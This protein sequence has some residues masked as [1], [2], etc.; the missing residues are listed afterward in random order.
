MPLV[1]PRDKE[2]R[3][4]FLERCMGDQTSVNDFPDRS[5]RFAVCNGLYNDKKEEDIKMLLEEEKYHKKPKKDKARVG[6]DEYDN[7]GEAGARAKEI[8]CSGV[9]SHDTP[10]GKVFMP[11]KTHDEYMNQLAKMKKPMEDDEEENKPKRHYGEEHDKDKK[12]KKKELEED[13]DCMDGT[14]GC[15]CTEKQIFFAEIKTEQEGVF[16]GYASTFGNVDN[17]NDIVAKGAFTKSLA[18]RPASKVKLL[19]QHKTDEPIGIFE[20]IFEDSKGLY[21]KGRL[22]LGTQK[23]RETYELMKMGAI[24]GMSIGFRANPEKQTYNES[25]RTRTLNE[26]Q[27]LEI[28][29][30]TF[31]MNERAIVQSVKGEKSIREWE[32]I[33]RD[34]GGLSRTEAKVGA[35]A[36]MDALNHRD[37]DTKQLADLIYKVANILSNKQTNI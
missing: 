36:L 33:L 8:G 23:G 30:V 2:K 27:L 19:S 11:C 12:P 4:D 15:G 14:C 18:E 1:K 16:M 32:T 21:V 26:V 9:H 28:S 31:P 10:S 5:Q 24:D 37:D 20:E 34:A 17:G 3:K 35:K 6:K 29:L 13:K 25:K 7:P 22:A